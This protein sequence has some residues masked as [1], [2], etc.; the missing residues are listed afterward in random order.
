MG[1]KDSAVDFVM[2]TPDHI[3]A[4]GTTWVQK[5]QQWILRR[6]HQVTYKLRPQHG[7]KRFS[8]GVCDESTRSHTS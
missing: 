4:E 8:S 3:Q 5:V 6:K 7:C 1:A 2:D